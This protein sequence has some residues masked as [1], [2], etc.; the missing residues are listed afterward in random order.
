M[1]GEKRLTSDRYI[2]HGK[3]IEVG[4]QFASSYPLHAHEFFEAE[5]V[6]SGEGKHVLNGVEYPIQAGSAYVLSP[7]DFHSVEIKDGGL[8]EVYHIALD[9]TVIPSHILQA[10]YNGNVCRVLGTE[11]MYRVTTACE[12][13]CKEFFSWGYHKPLCDYVLSMLTRSNRIRGEITPVRK[14]ILYVETHFRENPSLAEAAE[15]ACLSP[16]YFGNVFKQITGETYIS[17]LN[18][19]KVTCAKMLLESGC[20]VTEACF[21]SGFGSLSGFLHTF[22]KREGISPEQYKNSCRK[23]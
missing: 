20:T 21:A 6:I 15:Q 1:S 9:E 8:M 17:F 13:M 23:E 14:A 4:R 5:V 19:R 10:V 18:A 7:S 16:V 12:L 2:G 3:H 11:E 22:K